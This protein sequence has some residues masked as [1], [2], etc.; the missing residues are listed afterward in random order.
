MMPM[1]VTSRCWTLRP[2]RWAEGTAWG[3]VLG[4]GLVLAGCGSEVNDGKVTCRSP[5]GKTIARVEEW[6]YNRIREA[7]LQVLPA[8]G[9]PLAYSELSR[10]AASQI[11]AKEVQEIGKVPWFIETVSL[12]MEVR[13]ELARVQD[14]KPPKRLRR[15]R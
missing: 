14:G 6:K 10:R 15:V 1:Q 3:L 8:D 5:S 12:E 7:I 4:V 2:V 13:G 11:P 9:S